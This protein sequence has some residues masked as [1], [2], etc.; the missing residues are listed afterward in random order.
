MIKKKFIDELIQRF[1][2]L[3]VCSPD[4]EAAL[5]V[6]VQS[7]LDG[8]KLLAMGNGGSSAD[9]EH[10]CA[11]LTKGVYLERLLHD[12]ERKLFKDNDTILPSMLQSGLP[13]ISLGIAHSFITAFINDVH[14]EFMFA[15]QIWVLGRKPDTVLAISTSGNSKNVLIGLQTA[16]A[17]K[18]K[19][20]LLTGEKESLCS[21]VADISIRVPETAVH[22][23]QELH[24][25]VYHALCFELEHIFFDR[26]NGLHYTK[27][28]SHNA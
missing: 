23:V 16:K 3:S 26:E 2:K 24:L 12:E 22:K 17:R 28:N 20:I 11:E 15:Q 25:P 27:L 7:F 19:T 5:E 9:A 4:I 18:L 6:L 14:P 1:P 10:L 13:A 8:G 21:A